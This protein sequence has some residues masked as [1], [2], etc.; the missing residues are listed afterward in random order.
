MG[1]F[2]LQGG[3]MVPGSYRASPNHRL[4]TSNGFFRLDTNLMECLQ[5]ELAARSANRPNAP[6]PHRRGQIDRRKRVTL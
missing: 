4:L 2:R 3:V 6:E 5:R 1:A